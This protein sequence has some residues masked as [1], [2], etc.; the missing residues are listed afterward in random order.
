[1]KKFYQMFFRPAAKTQGSFLVYAANRREAESKAREKMI[2]DF[3]VDGPL[4]LI[5]SR[6]GGYRYR[7]FHDVKA[8]EL[9][10]GAGSALVRSLMTSDQLE[11]L[12]DYKHEIEEN[13]A[14]HLDTFRG[15]AS[16]YFVGWK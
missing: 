15:I 10:I 2:Q 13:P 1:M 7:F 6:T 5:A 16:L 4:K 3:G 12:R 11:F 9:G 8:A 14:C